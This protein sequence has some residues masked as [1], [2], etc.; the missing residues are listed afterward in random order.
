MRQYEDFN[1][2]RLIQ[3]ETIFNSRRVFFFCSL[4]HTVFMHTLIPI[5]TSC[6]G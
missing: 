3:T 6:L 2:I 1:L 5:V 4:F